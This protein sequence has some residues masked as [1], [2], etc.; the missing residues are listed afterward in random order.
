MTVLYA[1]SRSEMR[2]VLDQLGSPAPRML[3]TVGSTIVPVGNLDRVL[4]PAAGPGGLTKRDL[5]RYYTRAA[6]FLLGHLEGRPIGVVRY[7]YG[8]E[9]QPVHQAVWERYPPFVETL[10]IPSENGGAARLQCQVSNLATLLWLGQL[11]A[12]ELYPW[13]SRVETRDGHW[14]RDDRYRGRYRYRDAVAEPAGLDQPD[15][16]VVDLYARGTC[17]FERVREAAFE[18]RRIAQALG[19]TPY[20]K[21]SGRGGVH[22]LMPIVRGPTFQEVREMAEMIGPFLDAIGRR[23]RAIGAMLGD[24]VGG[25]LC[26]TGGNARGSALVAALSP[27]ACAFA[28][29]SMPLTWTELADAQ[30]IEFT[31]ETV[32]DLLDHCGDAWHG[33]GEAAGRWDPGHRGD[34]Q[35]DRIGAAK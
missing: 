34:P 5:L 32:P 20:V 22:C 12:I 6:P 14:G 7:P 10:P 26:D 15:C 23:G 9:R 21:T 19:L 1:P 2:S 24:G 30:P 16:L 8:I 31:L 27:R 11:G 28:T 17:S 4:W 35:G 29:V 25:V 33:M 18:V 3:L 13:L